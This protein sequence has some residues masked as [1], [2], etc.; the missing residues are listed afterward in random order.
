MTTLSLWHLGSHA[1]R[2]FLP[3]IADIIDVADAT[4]TVLTLMNHG[5]S[6]ITKSNKIPD[7]R[8]RKKS[9][10]ILPGNAAVQATKG[11]EV[12]SAFEASEEVTAPLTI[13]PDITVSVPVVTIL[14]GSSTA[15]KVIGVSE[16][17]DI[18]S[19][20]D[21]AIEGTH[22]IE[23]AGALNATQEADT[24]HTD[25]TNATSI[26]EV[27]TAL[28][29]DVIAND[30]PTLEVTKTEVEELHSYHHALPATPVLE[31]NLA[32]KMVDDLGASA[33]SSHYNKFERFLAPD[34]MWGVPSP[35]ERVNRQIKRNTKTL[36]RLE[37]TAEN[38]KASTDNAKVMLGSKKG[39][40]VDATRVDIPHNPTEVATDT[41]LLS[42]ADSDFSTCMRQLSIKSNSSDD[43]L[44][45]AETETVHSA[46]STPNTIYS[47]GDSTEQSSHDEK[48]HHPIIPEIIITEPSEVYPENADD[49]QPALQ[50]EG[51]IPT[52]ASLPPFSGLYDYAALN[53]AQE[54]LDDLWIMTILTRPGYVTEYAKLNCGF[55]YILEDSKNVRLMVE[56][57][58]EEFV[59]WIGE[60]NTIGTAASQNNEPGNDKAEE[61]KGLEIL[62]GPEKNED[63]AEGEGEDEEEEDW[64]ELLRWK[65]RYELGRGWGIVESFKHPAFTDRKYALGND[66]RWYFEYEGKYR[67][68]I[69]DEMDLLHRRRLEICYGLVDVIGEKS[70][71]NSWGLTNI[72]EEEE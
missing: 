1:C 35:V 65:R 33:S 4:F 21:T 30:D 67:R 62:E 17:K 40:D 10:T 34:R 53:F 23:L 46:I 13:N 39:I 11:P 3:T 41:C 52:V 66:D 59:H 16:E 8:R 5:S 37:K 9:R 28:P 43:T 2:L 71:T 72:T 56:D 31:I 61:S 14:E 49:T 48:L 51:D 55:W 47:P 7:K 25:T 38:I 22:N 50:S 19:I 54:D 26:Q 20:H 45:T 44:P 64:S 57:E 68:L 70:A 32:Q 15:E 6:R 69:E 12:I 27:E 24:H 42:N 58:Y 36:G 18:T 60:V 63:A 29:V